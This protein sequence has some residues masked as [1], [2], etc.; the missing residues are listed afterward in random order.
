LAIQNNP[1]CIHIGC[2]EWHYRQDRDLAEANAMCERCGFSKKEDAMR[3]AIPLTLCDDG[4]K[5]KLIPPRQRKE[6]Q[7]DPGRETDPGA[8]AKDHEA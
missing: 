2:A 7:N 5:R 8:S 6:E 3:K 4:L 1:L